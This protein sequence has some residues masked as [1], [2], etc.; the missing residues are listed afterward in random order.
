M[1]N[2]LLT[3]ANGFAGK[4][5]ADYLKLKGYNILP[6]TRNDVD[7]EKTD[8]IEE[9]A[10]N[11][12]PNKIDTIIHLAFKMASP[13][14][15]EYEQI[16]VFNQN[17][18]ITQNLIKIAQ[19]INPQKLINFSS[20][21]VYPNVDGNFD[22]NSVIKTSKNTD[23]MYGLAKFCAENMFDNYLNNVEI[24][25][26]RIAQIF[27]EKMRSDRIIPI[28]K[29]ELED[30]NQITVY[31]NGERESCFISIKKLCETVE[32]FIKNNKPG[33]YNTGEFNISYYNL[34]KKTIEKYGN[35][36]SK[37]I[38]VDKGSKSKFCLNLDKLNK[39]MYN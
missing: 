34:A 28:M 2:I 20:M 32:F 22:E 27:A 14:Q 24:T 39:L 21:A 1:A 12:L 11:L 36:N 18:I 25:H 38:K 5:L 8:Y 16:S 9:F 35:S 17:I 10:N 19:I 7:L 15:T 33:I 13:K 30:S 37:I 3:G 4:N 29:K 31:G 6:L 26:L 23:C